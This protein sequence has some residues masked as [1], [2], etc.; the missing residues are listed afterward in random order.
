VPAEQAD[1][2]IAADRRVLASAKGEVI[3]IA[4]EPLTN[5][6]G[7]TR[8]LTSRKVALRDEHGAA[9]HVL[10][11]AF[12]IT[13]RKHAKEM[14]RATADRLAQSEHFVR[15]VTDNLPGM[16][17][18]WDAGLRCRFANRYFL[19]WHGQ[20]DA[21]IMGAPMP[22]WSATRNSAASR[23][24]CRR[25]WAASRR[26]SPA[27]CAGRPARSH[28]WVNYIPDINDSGTVQGFFVLVSDV[29]ELKETELHLQQLNEELIGAR[30]RAEAAS[31][32]KSEFLANMS[33]EIR[34]PM[35]AI[36]GLARLLEE[37]PLAPRERGY[38][39]KIQ[40]ATHSLLGLVNDVLDFSRVE[41]GQ[42]ELEHAAFSMR[43]L[44]D[45]ISVMVSGSAHDKGIELIYDIDPALP[46]EV[47][48]DPRRLQQVLLNLM[49]NAIKFTERGEVALSVRPAGAQAGRPRGADRIPRARHRHRHCRRQANRH[50]RRL[51]AGRQQ[52]Q[53]ALR[54]RRAG[55]AICRQLADMMG[56]A[57]SVASEPGRGSEFLFSLSAGMHRA[58][59]RAAGARAGGR[60]VGADRRRQR[61]RAAS[62]GNVLPRFR[63]DGCERRRR[64]AGAG[65]A[66]GSRRRRKPTT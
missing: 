16:V 64:R 8:F 5:A 14:L 48:G 33:H 46:A 31:R 53:P 30:D 6:A 12:D 56:G 29:T 61:Q 22:R 66:A 58:G 26:D 37:A 28:T 23:S 24:T 49:G 39:D 45:S 17:A 47:A 11:I 21:Q 62:A 35:N 63:L 54:R 59:R 3:E 2:F 1:M 50:L 42:L 32:A 4:E 40:V 18:Y 52:H 13:E 38:L 15:A 44:L 57:I 60:L 19:D 65:H 7:T 10:G 9:T 25:R 34:T 41:A 20:S 55:L 36:T 27:I 51:L 43:R